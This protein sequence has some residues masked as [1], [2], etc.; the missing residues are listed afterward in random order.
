[1]DNAY[2]KTPFYVLWL[3]EADMIH[4]VRFERMSYKGAKFVICYRHLNLIKIDSDLK[5]IICS[6]LYVSLTLH[7]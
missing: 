3:V 7:L 5:C 4:N 2:N 6:E 1:M